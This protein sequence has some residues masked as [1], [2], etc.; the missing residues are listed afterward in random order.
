LVAVCVWYLA[1]FAAARPGRLRR[2]APGSRGAR[3]AAGGA[4]APA[5]LT[6]LRRPGPWL[7][8]TLRALT[9]VLVRDA[10]FFLADGPAPIPGSFMRAIF[11]Q[12]CASATRE[13]DKIGAQPKLFIIY[14]SAFARVRGMRRRHRRRSAA[15]AASAAAVAVAA[16]SLALLL[17]L[18]PRCAHAVAV[19]GPPTP[20]ETP[21]FARVFWSAGG[22]GVQC[23]G[24]LIA[25]SCVATAAHCVR[26]TAATMSAG[27]V[28]LPLAPGGGTFTVTEAHVHPG[29]VPLGEH[30]VAVLRLDA[31]AWAPPA[32][33]ACAPGSWGNLPRGATLGVAGAGLNASNVRTGKV[34]VAR[35][36]AVPD[37]GCVFPPVQ[38][39]D[40][41]VLHDVCAGTCCSRAVHPSACA[42]DSGGQ[43]F[44]NDTVY[45]LV[46]R[47]DASHGCGRAIVPEIYTDL[48]QNCA[49]IASVV[50]GTTQGFTAV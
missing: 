5:T 12:C 16:A 14:P 39:T 37:G 10:P 15:A 19:G 2:F 18:L 43:L 45:A 27:S 30:D 20:N 40:T 28:A 47:G 41:Q 49:F 38:L 26:F 36:P 33:V 50:G 44:L 22:V 23:G 17:L 8:L 48:S 34:N 42:G 46:S 32:R 4:A 1:S 6:G 21:W 25:P 7:T 11:T 3:G 29:W 24:V 13:I 9:A 35:V 31:P